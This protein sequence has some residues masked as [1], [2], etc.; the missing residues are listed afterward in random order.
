MYLPFLT[1]SPIGIIDGGLWPDDKWHASPEMNG[2]MNEFTPAKARKDWNKDCWHCD[3][4]TG[5]QT[6]PNQQGTSGGMRSSHS[7]ADV[8]LPDAIFASLSTPQTITWA[9]QLTAGTAIML[10]ACQEMSRSGS[11][12]ASRAWRTLCW[13]VAFFAICG[14]TEAKRTCAVRWEDAPGDLMWI[15][16]PLSQPRF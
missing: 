7:S 3:K 8:P 11:K 2:K 10:T 5:N 4:Y 12:P 9:S 16:P 15:V 1:L 14:I 13:T 6:W